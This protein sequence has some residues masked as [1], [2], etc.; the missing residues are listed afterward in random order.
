VFE[1]NYWSDAA[2]PDFDDD[3]VGDRPYRLS[4]V[5]DHLRGNLTAA[6]LFAQGLGATVIA[7]A[8]RAFPVLEAVSVQ[9][10]RPLARMPALHD[11]PARAAGTT[12]R[13]VLGLVA[14]AA[15]VVGGCLV[16]FAG[17]RP[18]AARKA[19]T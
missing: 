16:L 1:G 15:G 4:N 13:T 17:R 7:G 10:A 8:E 3:G 19:V 12:T 14:S 6:D 2:E 18:R 5:F 9:D 11:V